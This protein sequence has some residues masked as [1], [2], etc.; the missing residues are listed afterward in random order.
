VQA[1][2]VA[3]GLAKEY[4][5]GGGVRGISFAVAPGEVVGVVGPPA[6]GKS[7]LLGLL[8]TRLLPSRGS[9]AVLGHRVAAHRAPDR[10]VTAV[11]RSLGV[12]LEDAPV[13]G[14]LTGWEN[15]WMLGRLQ[16]LRGRDLQRRL[17]V[18]FDWA[19]MG[20]QAHHPART[21]SYPMRRK[22]GLIQALV[23]SPPVLLMDEPFHGLDM[24]TRM[25]LQEAMDHLRQKG[26]AVVV[27]ARSGAELG[28]L[29]TRLLLFEAG[30]LVADGPA[31]AIL[32]R[33]SRSSVIE[34][35]LGGSLGAVELQAIPGRCAPLEL[36]GNGLR[37]RVTNPDAALGPL[38]AAVAAAGGRVLAVDVQRPHPEGR[39]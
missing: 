7:T 6:S 39:L 8:A 29:C 23:H 28:A 34:V 19:G 18:L 31:D 4:P 25:A 14:D 2:I 32:Q 30:D 13:A 33:Y 20:A 21:Y 16:A 38:L 26:A 24:P 9:Y 5:A 10:T 3:S 11:R 17:E 15:A 27:A 36:T 12:L 35:R 22:L 1:A 37:L